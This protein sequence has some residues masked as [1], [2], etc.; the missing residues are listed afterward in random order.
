MGLRAPKPNIPGSTPL[1]TLE[2]APFLACTV[3]YSSGWLD[4]NSGNPSCFCLPKTY[5]FDFAFQTDCVNKTLT[6]AGFALLSTV[7]YTQRVWPSV[8]TRPAP[9]SCGFC[10]RLG[11]LQPVTVVVIHALWRWREGSRTNYSFCTINLW[12][13]RCGNQ[14]FRH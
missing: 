5:H 11:C 4:R 13:C 7:H 14:C 8:R 10:S 2:N 12:L 6:E 9:S 3:V 1:G